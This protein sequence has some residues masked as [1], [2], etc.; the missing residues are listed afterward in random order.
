[1][2]DQ[3]RWAGQLPDR[4]CY[5]FNVV[6]NS[7]P[8]QFFLPLTVTVSAQ[9]DSMGGVAM[10]SE[11]IEKMHIPT[12]G[13]VQGSVYKQERRRV[14][15]AGRIFGNDFEFHN[16]PLGEFN[17]LNVILRR[18]IKQSVLPRAQHRSCESAQLQAGS[19]PATAIKRSATLLSIFVKVIQ[20]PLSR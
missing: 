10:L 16:S 19:K 14:C 11:V 9:I 6:R 5:I 8:A 1:M 12:P 4:I 20:N 17:Q 15:V 18:W 7:G 2:A 3:N 13:S